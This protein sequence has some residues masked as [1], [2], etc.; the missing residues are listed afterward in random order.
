V[1]FRSEGINN[2]NKKTVS[3]LVGF[4]IKES[5]ILQILKDPNM[6]QHPITSLYHLCDETRMRNY[7]ADFEEKRIKVKDLGAP[8]NQMENYFRKRKLKDKFSASKIALTFK[9]L[10]KFPKRDH[11]FNGIRSAQVLSSK[12]YNSQMEIVRKPV[13]TVL[14]YDISPSVNETTEL[15]ELQKLPCATH[16]KNKVLWFH[17]KSI[18]DGYQF[19]NP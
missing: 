10:L 7:E 11:K 17:R 5:D 12:D 6:K 3:E 1:P 18:S 14:D 19:V 8:F 16:D 4:G 15:K 13:P 9:K 2:P